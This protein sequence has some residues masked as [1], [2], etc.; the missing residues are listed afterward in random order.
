MHFVDTMTWELFYPDSNE[1]TV[2]RARA[3]HFAGAINRRLYV[4]SGR[5]SYKF[6]SSLDAYGRQ[7]C[8][9]NGVKINF[10][11]LMMKSTLFFLSM[12][13]FILRMAVF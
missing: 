4:W 12:N 1:D 11:V 13:S 7:M 10:F 9:K 8:T 5:E 2:P 3:G 6:T